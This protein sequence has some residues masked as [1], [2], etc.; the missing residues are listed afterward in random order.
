M[1]SRITLQQFKG[2]SHELELKQL[3]LFR[4]RSGSGKTAWLEAVRVGVLGYEPALGKQTSATIALSSGEQM[5]VQAGIHIPKR[6]IL[7]TGPYQR[8]GK[9][10]SDSLAHDR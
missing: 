6:H 8:Q 2:I 1:I 5:S 10:A 9:T 7:A 3:N 4:G